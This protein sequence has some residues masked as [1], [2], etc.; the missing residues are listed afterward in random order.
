MDVIAS[1][2]IRAIAGS[3]GLVLAIP[4][5]VLISGLMYTNKKEV[6]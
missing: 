1:E 4:V 2:I 6:G 3:I 5:T